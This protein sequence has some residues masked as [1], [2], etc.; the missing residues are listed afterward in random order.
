MVTA[1]L[2]STKVVLK[3]AE[4]SQT[5]S[6]CNTVATDENLF[7]LGQAVSKLEAQDVE[8]VTKVVESTLIQE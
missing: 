7:A 1:A 3:L 6:G 8:A 4:G 5:I 2:K